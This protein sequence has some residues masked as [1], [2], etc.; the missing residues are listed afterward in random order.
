MLLLVNGLRRLFYLCEWLWC[1]ERVGSSIGGIEVKEEWSNIWSTR[2]ER[3]H[4]Y[5]IYVLC[6]EVPE[7]EFLHDCRRSPF[8]VVSSSMTGGHDDLRR[9]VVSVMLTIKYDT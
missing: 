6:T 8:R 5:S 7:L 2:A 4:M 1:I 3:V 9:L